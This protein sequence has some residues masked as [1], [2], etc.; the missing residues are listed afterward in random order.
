MIGL[1]RMG[2]NIA[3]RLMQDGHECVVY[4]RDPAA[5]AQA[6]Q[7][8]R[9]RRVDLADLVASSS[10]RALVWVMLP[11]GA[12]TE[13]TVAALGAHA[14]A[15]RHHHRRRQHLLQGRHPPREGAGGE[16]RP[17][18]RCR[19]LRR[20]LGAGAR[21]LHDDRRR[22]RRRSTHLDP[23]FEAL[24]PGI[25][26]DRAHAGPRGRAIRAPSRAISMPGPAGAG[27]FVKMV[28]NG[29]EY[30]LMQAYAEGFDILQERGIR[31]ACRRTS[32]STSTS[33]TSPRSGGAAA[34]SP[35][36]CST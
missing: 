16:G 17:L 33:P 6:G 11:A 21:L 30:G 18:C 35:P 29:I 25:G 13:D 20:R 15:G 26:D 14:E 23:I 8:G 34:W 24:A 31:R 36:G 32:A 22:A 1:G 3:R 19:H 9:D 28:H 12:P 27:H 7:R 2:G 5:V 10:R 4:D